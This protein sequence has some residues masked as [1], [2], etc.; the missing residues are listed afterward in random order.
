MKVIDRYFDAK[1]GTYGER[2]LDIPDVITE[3]EAT[4]RDAAEALRETRRTRIAEIRFL[5]IELLMAA[6]G[7]DTAARQQIAA[8]RTEINTLRQQGI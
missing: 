2:E 7:G 4:I 1:T 5:V 3:A 6:V 8:L